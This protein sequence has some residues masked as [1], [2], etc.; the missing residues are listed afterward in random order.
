MFMYLKVEREE[1]EENLDFEL[2]GPSFF[3]LLHTPLIAYQFSSCAQE[4]KKLAV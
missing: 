4:E 2:G 1:E 3:M